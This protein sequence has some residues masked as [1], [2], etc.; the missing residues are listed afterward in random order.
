VASPCL[1]KNLIIIQRVPAAKSKK[2]PSSNTGFDDFGS[3]IGQAIQRNY[4]SGDI[5]A[6]TIHNFGFFAFDAKFVRSP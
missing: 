3:G 4:L 2:V 1:F 5:T 6:T